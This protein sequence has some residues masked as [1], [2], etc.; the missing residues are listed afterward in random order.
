MIAKKRCLA[1]T[2]PPFRPSAPRAYSK[3]ASRQLWEKFRGF[4]V[5]R[6]AARKYRS[7]SSL[8]HHLLRDPLGDAP[9]CKRNEW[10]AI[11]PRSRW[12]R[13]MLARFASRHRMGGYLFF[14]SS[15]L[16]LPRLTKQHPFTRLPQA[17]R[18]RVFNE[19]H[20]GISGC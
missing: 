3:G 18:L 13:V 12:G 1:M 11:P 7:R 14:K 17:L 4:L 6:P 10:L 15:G 20:R 5:P 19:A 9:L 2:R 16:L 8:P